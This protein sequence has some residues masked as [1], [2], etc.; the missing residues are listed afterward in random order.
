MSPDPLANYPKLIGDQCIEPQV[1]ECLQ[2]RGIDIVPLVELTGT[3]DLDDA[4]VLAVAH[5]CQ[6]ALLTY[7]KDATD[8]GALDNP[9]S[10]RLVVVRDRG[11]NFDSMARRIARALHTKDNDT[12]A[13]TVMVIEAGR[14]RVRDAGGHTVIDGFDNA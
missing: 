8:F 5:Q 1:L 9:K 6:R 4:D 13:G 11:T 3:G 12:V 2:D 14:T 10:P 7:D